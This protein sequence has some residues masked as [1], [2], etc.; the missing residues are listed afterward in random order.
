MCPA[1]PELSIENSNSLGLPGSA[2][3][4]ERN[5]EAVGATEAPLVEIAGRT[6]LVAVAEDPFHPVAQEVVD[7]EIGFAGIGAGEPECIFRVGP[8]CTDEKLLTARN[9]LC[10]PH[11]FLPEADLA[12]PV[13]SFYPIT[14]AFIRVRIFGAHAQRQLRR[15][16]AHVEAEGVLAVVLKSLLPGTTNLEPRTGKEESQAPA[17]V[18]LRIDAL[19]ADTGGR[20]VQGVIHIGLSADRETS[21]E[22]RA[23]TW[24]SADGQSQR[25]RLQETNPN[26]IQPLVEDPKWGEESA[27]G[28]R[29]IRVR[30]VVH[31]GVIHVLVDRPRVR[32]ATRR[33]LKVF[34]KFRTRLDQP[35]ISQWNQERRVD[36]G[37]D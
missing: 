27:S 12:Q 13:R 15:L 3:R 19:N 17:N 11:R 10:A 30:D 21:A 23:I 22:H 34:F 9:E 7:A 25:I 1:Q 16:P 28:H 18:A 37:V 29:Q 24:C 6:E 14:T 36:L 20:D 4:A 26:R 31:L 32:P 5:Q 35:A 33:T 2:R 8:D